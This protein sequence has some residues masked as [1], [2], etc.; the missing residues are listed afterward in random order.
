MANLK[1]SRPLLVIIGLSVAATIGIA[2]A[3]A[4]RDVERTPEIWTADERLLV[5][6][7]ESGDIVVLD[8][9]RE[10]ERI[11]T[12]LAPISLARSS[13]GTL[14]VALRGRNTDR[15]HVTIIDTAYDES[16]GE[17][18]RPYVARTFV[19]QSPGGVSHGRL[20]EFDGVLG[21]AEEGTGLL[22]L[23][24][25]A[26]VSGL[27]AATGEQ[28]AWHG[29]CPGLHGGTAAGDSVL[30]G[31]GN[32]ILVT[33][34][35]PQSEEPAHVVSYPG[36]GR[37]AAFHTGRDGVRW[38][39]TEGAQS[40]LHRIDTTAS[41]PTIERL[42]LANGPR[43]RTAIRTAA[44][45]GGEYLLVLT[46]QGFL[47][48]RDGG[49]GA[50]LRETRI[51]ERFDLDFHEHVDRAEAPDLA[52]AVT[53]VHVSLPGAGRIVKVDLASGRVLDKVKV[54][55]MPTRMVLLS[56]S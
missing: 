8:D 53:H 15:D 21:I 46:H 33:P 27:D 51:G 54:D 47:Q 1:A 3:I 22:H 16:T 25:P 12:P 39:S 23:L 52:P 35:D 28:L 20:P 38:G 30:F 40:A 18:R 11:S 45:P 41:T 10:V 26:S 6:D 5:A 42:E 4:H 43:T 48:I 55:G 7:S 29:G 31:C 9:L 34:M 13:D 56:Q 2:P 36:E 17:A 14:A 24:D 37:V 32:G 19:A 49:S 44:T 50:L